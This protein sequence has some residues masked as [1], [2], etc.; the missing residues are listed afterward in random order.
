MSSAL[1]GRV[2][3]VS[4]ADDDFFRAQL[5]AMVDPRLQLA[6]LARRMSWSE[7]EASLAPLGRRPRDRNLRSASRCPCCQKLLRWGNEFCRAGYTVIPF[8]NKG[9]PM[10]H[11]SLSIATAAL[12]AFGFSAHAQTAH[13]ANTPGH[14]GSG[15][16]NL[17][18]AA[19]AWK[20]TAAEYRALYH[21]GYNIA[22]M[23]LE[24]AIKERKQGD[25]PL[26]VVS[27]LD[28][29][30]LLPLPY[31]GYLI[32][33][34]KDFFDDPAWDAWI[35]KN[36][37]VVAPGAQAFFQYAAD[38][39]V[40][41]FYVS[42][43]EQGERTQEYG[44]THVRLAGLPFADNEHVTM[45]RETSNKEKRQGEIAQ[46]FN[47][48]LFLGDNLNDFRRKYYTTN[49]DERLKLMEEDQGLY[50]SKYI[51]FPNPTDGHWIRAIFGDS[52]P[53]SNDT[54]RDTFKKAA[55]RQAWDGR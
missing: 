12:C 24:R 31:W 32:N 20:Q 46:K 16:N 43:R 52:E 4:M 14:S 53:P 54:N 48:V 37:M 7:I 18:I 22:R 36:K 3:M 55:T 40:E 9:L 49:V 26:A 34:N 28:D 42:S 44:V 6:V 17:L 19:V 29:T 50:G 10:R 21:Q 23:H 13:A 25:K 39:G 35:P 11:L 41:V 38:N 15:T 51:L 27:D 8:V 45:L 33:Q 1:E 30:V 5:D 47:I 2:R